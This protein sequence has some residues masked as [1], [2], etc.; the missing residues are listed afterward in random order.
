M[1]IFSYLVAVVRNFFFR[2]IAC[3][4]AYFSNQ[5]TSDVDTKK[6]KFIKHTEVSVL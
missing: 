4:M 1:S 5:R 2:F 6:M 3:I